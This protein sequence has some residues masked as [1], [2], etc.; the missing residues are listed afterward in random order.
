MDEAGSVP[1]VQRIAA[2]DARVTV[3]GQGYVGLTLGCEAAEA[4]FQVIGFDVD[5]ERVRCLST[6]TMCVPGVSEALFANA[7]GTG[8]MRF[9]SD[10]TSVA[11]ADVVAICVPT[12]LRDHAPDLS[13]IEAATLD[14]AE[15]LRP[16]SLVILESTTYPGTT[17]E[18]VQGIIRDAGLEAGRDYLLAYS[19]ERIDP[20]NAEFGMRNTPRIVGGVGT[21]ATDATVAFYSHLVDKVVPVSSPRAA[22]A[23]KL[24]ENT[25]RHVNI[26]LVNEMAMLCHE[27]G[28]DVW[29]VLHAA[30]TKPFG[31]MAFEPGPGVGGHCIP[32]DP[33]Y[34]AWK[35]RRESGRRF[36]VLD[37]AQDVNDRMPNYVVSRIGSLLNDRSKSVRGSKVLALGVTYKP[38]V[39]DTRESPALQTMQVLHRRGAEVRYHD[40]YIDEVPLNGGTTTCLDLDEGLAWADLAVLLTP[41]S[42]FDLLKIAES[43]PLVFDT[44]N[45]FG[46]ARPSNVIPL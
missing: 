21:E 34:F 5:A 27:M 4:G 6:G 17:E 10:H 37:Q 15:H 11:D 9:S 44:R 20:G 8:R 14:L 42:S 45:A 2:A 23:S 24:L 43:V 31:Y 32:L 26:G 12:P 22:E 46:F 30:S 33:T 39:P 25:F 29:E 13:F 16:G 35:V 3:I 38:D 36:G 18:V 19:P 40:P 7:F 41:H 1:L 28:I